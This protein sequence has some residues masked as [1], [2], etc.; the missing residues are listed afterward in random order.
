LDISI[1]VNTVHG[2]STRAF[3]ALHKASP[4]KSVE[5]LPSSAPVQPGVDPERAA[6]PVS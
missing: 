3:R 4:R 1:L 6:Q 2:V 5:A